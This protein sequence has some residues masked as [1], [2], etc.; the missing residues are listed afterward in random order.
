[1]I[2][3][4]DM[5]YATESMVLEYNSGVEHCIEC[6]SVEQGCTIFDDSTHSFLDV[7]VES[8]RQLRMLYYLG[9]KFD[10]YTVLNAVQRLGETPT[11]IKIAKDNK[12]DLG[13]LE[14]IR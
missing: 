11:L 10:F 14:Q 8:E 5:C 1:M 6:Y 4:C 3:I 13:Y 2:T 7:T 9:Y 12:Y